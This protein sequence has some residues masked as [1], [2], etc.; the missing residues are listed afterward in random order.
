MYLFNSTPNSGMSIYDRLTQSRILFLRQPI[1]DEVANLLI[2]QLAYL[3]GEDPDTAIKL[4]IHTEAGSVAAGLAIYDTIQNLQSEVHTI[5]TGVADGIGSLLLAIGTPGKRWAQPH[6]RI[7]LAQP[8]ASLNLGTAHEIEAVAREV[9]RQRQILSELYAQATGQ[10]IER[11]AED[12]TQRA[13]MSATEAQTY[14]L[15]D[16]IQ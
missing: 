14:G 15:I 2:A 16:L 13:F 10:P 5:C 6:A 12:I 9:F 1:T 7:R 8:E 4:Y 11:I 3:D